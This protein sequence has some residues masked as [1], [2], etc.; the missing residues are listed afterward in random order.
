V[1]F[2]RFQWQVRWGNR[3]GSLPTR[4]CGGQETF[5]SYCMAGPVWKTKGGGATGFGAKLVT[6]WICLSVWQAKKDAGD[7]ELIVD[8]SQKEGD[9]SI[10]VH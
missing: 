1:I 9:R 4:I 8:E 6:E 2:F 3:G 5:R 7:D 10:Q